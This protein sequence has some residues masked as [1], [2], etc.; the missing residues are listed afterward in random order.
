MTYINVHGGYELGT[1]AE[2]VANWCVDHFEILK[3]Q[4]LIFR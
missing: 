1:V 2:Q 3:S 4:L